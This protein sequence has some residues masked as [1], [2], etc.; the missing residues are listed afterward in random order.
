MA[1]A[2]VYRDVL[3]ETGARD[4]GLREEA[5]RRITAL[6]NAENE[7][8]GI[9]LGYAYK[10]S[11]VVFPE[12]CATYSDDPLVYTPTTAPGV[13][14]PS[15][16]GRD[17]VALYDRLGP[18]FTLL[19]FAGQPDRTWRDAALHRCI[20]LDIVA[21]EDARLARIYAADLVLVRPDQHIAWRGAADTSKTPPDSILA[22]VT[23][24]DTA[25]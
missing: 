17:G 11:P 12:P 14:L 20:P 15:T 3:G 10:D 5:G 19:S 1:I 18:W 8:W 13:R 7:S 21:I 9:E 24:W 6:G 22:R 23:G 25:R 16:Y 2:G 4:P